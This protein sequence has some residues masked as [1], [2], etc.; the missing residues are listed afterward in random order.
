[1]GPG[2]GGGGDQVEDPGSGLVLM[3]QR[4]QGACEDLQGGGKAAE[5]VLSKESF[6]EFSCAPLGRVGNSRR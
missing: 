4:S 2:E 1:M 3:V 5:P 6:D